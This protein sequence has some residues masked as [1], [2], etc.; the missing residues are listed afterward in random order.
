MSWTSILG[1]FLLCWVL[2]DLFNGSVWL[3][4]QFERATEPMAYWSTLALWLGVAISCFF[5]QL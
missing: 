4:R 2:W 5:W 3:H 1:I